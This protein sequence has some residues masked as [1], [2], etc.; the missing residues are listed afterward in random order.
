MTDTTTST[1]TQTWRQQYTGSKPLRKAKETV[2]AS[3]T[4]KWFYI[5]GFWSIV[6]ILMSVPLIKVNNVV[7]Q[8]ALIAIQLTWWIIYLM[9]FSTCAKFDESILTIK[10]MIADYKG[11]HEVCKF[12][13][14]TSMLMTYIPVK[15]VHSRGLIE[16]TKGRFGVLIEYFP[17]TDPGDQMESHLLK[18]QA[19]IN[20]LAGDMQ[21]N[22]ISSSR[23]GTQTPLLKKFEKMINDPAVSPKNVSLIL[24]QYSTIKQSRP[25][26]DWAFYISLGLGSH[27][28]VEDAL[29]RLD[30][31][32]PGFLDGLQDAGITAS[33]IISETE[34]VKNYIQF[35][36]PRNL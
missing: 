2:Y 19:L 15:K 24:S 11:T 17:P 31:E 25:T 35:M 10:F 5:T 26:P 12:D 16:Y 1:N 9:H 20:R 6:S 8:C 14:D 32:V 18:I 34:I 36:V 30:T 33:Q 23:F 28:T 7:I 29:D 22:F 13:M 3:I 21:A 4:P 27:A